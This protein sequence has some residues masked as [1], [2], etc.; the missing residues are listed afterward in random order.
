MCYL[1][2]TLPMS[3][4]RVGIFPLTPLNRYHSTVQNEQ[5]RGYKFHHYHVHR[6]QLPFKLFIPSLYELKG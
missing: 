3:E 4:G 6:V 1:C 5:S 2:D